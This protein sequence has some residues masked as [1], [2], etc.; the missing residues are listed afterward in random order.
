MLGYHRSNHKKHFI[1]SIGT[2][3]VFE[4]PA[5][6]STTL[7]AKPQYTIGTMTDN[8]EETAYEDLDKIAQKASTALDKLAADDVEGAQEQLHD[9][10]RRAEAWDD[11]Q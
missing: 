10:K 3:E 9:I 1:H 4:K 5:L 6:S 7:R 11:P 8:L 2:S